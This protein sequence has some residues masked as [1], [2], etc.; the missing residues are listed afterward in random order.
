MGV[1]GVYGFLWVFMGF[2]VSVCIGGYGF[3]GA[4]GFLWVFVHFHLRNA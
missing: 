2:Q 1:R 3:L 4:C